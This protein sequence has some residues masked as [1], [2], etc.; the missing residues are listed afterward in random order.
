VALLQTA[1]AASESLRQAVA[2]DP[3]AGMI[4]E[5]DPDQETAL[6]HYSKLAAEQLVSDRELLAYKDE[7]V[8]LLS[9]DLRNPLTTITGFS[10]L[11]QRRARQRPDGEQEV[12]DLSRVLAQ[13]KH[14]ATL[15]DLLVVSSRGPAD[16]FGA[17][18][19]ETDLGGLLAETVAQVRTGA[20]D[21]QWRLDIEECPR[22]RCDPDRITQVL[23]NLLQNAV[24]YS[25]SGSAITVTLRESAEQ[26]ILSVQDQGV[27]VPNDDQVR[28][29]QRFQRGSN[30]AGIAPGLGAGLYI[31]SRIV[32]AHAGQ[33]WV[34]SEVGKGSIFYVALPF[35]R[36]MAPIAPAVGGG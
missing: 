17:S 5:E 6:L 33:T 13:L 15:L 12:A 19:R 4:V 29:F 2:A 11:L 18:M 34:E 35:Q 7:V 3:E 10:T 27:G 24:K 30:V 26:A 22:V 14:M 25:P 16:I 36:E 28:I 21:H 9:H 1:V 8:S 31:V 20:P 23:T 32:L